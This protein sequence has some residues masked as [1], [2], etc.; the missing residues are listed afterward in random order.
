MKDGK[1]CVYLQAKV[2]I[3]RKSKLTGLRISNFLQQYFGQR[4]NQ[5]YLFVCSLLKWAEAL[6][7]HQYKIKKIV[8]NEYYKN[9]KGCNLQFLFSYLFP[10]LEYYIEFLHIMAFIIFTNI[11]NTYLQVFRLFSRLERLWTRGKQKFGFSSKMFLVIFLDV[12]PLSMLQLQNWLYQLFYID[13]NDCQIGRSNDEQAANTKVIF[14]NLVKVLTWKKR[15]KIVSRSGKNLPSKQ[16]H[17]TFCVFYFKC[18]LSKKCR[19]LQF[20]V[21]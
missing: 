17:H 14:E 20:L 18:F 10:W 4:I 6:M 3:S 21:N 5:F 15:K 11:T 13:V 16:Q 7:F 2:I 8:S 9:S 12:S 1:V 19:L